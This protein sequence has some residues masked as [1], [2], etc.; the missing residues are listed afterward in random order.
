MVV[1]HALAYGTGDFN[2]HYFQLPPLLSYLLFFIYGVFF[3]IG[4]VTNLFASTEGFALYFLKD[5]TVFY[6]LG[7]FFLS[8]LP[9]LL[10]IYLVYRIYSI[11]F[12]R[13][14]ALFSALLMSVV[15]LN[16]INSHYL[17]HDM[18]MISFILLTYLRLLRLEKCYSLRNYI[19]AAIFL[20]CAIATKYNAALMAAPF[21]ITHIFLMKKQKVSLRGIIFSKYLWLSFLA[22][23][24]TFILLNPFALLGFREFITSFSKQTAAA[25]NMGWFHHIGYSLK[26]GIS[27]PILISGII[28]LISILLLEGK[29]AAI[30]LSFPVVFY[31]VLVFYSQPFS[32]YVL[33]LIP[34]LAMGSAYI[35]YGVIFKYF[36]NQKAKIAL[37]LFTALLATPTTIKSIDADNILRKKDTRIISAEW[38]KD[39]VPIGSRIAC[40]DT[41]FRP[42]IKQPYLQVQAKMKTLSSEKAADKAK[43]KKQNYLLKILDKQ[44]PG[45]PVYFLKTEPQ[46]QGQ[47]LN[48]MPSV[49]FNIDDL[50]RNSIDYVIINH[51]ITNKAK[52]DFMPELKKNSRLIKT[53][54]P[55]N[56]GLVR[57]SYD[58]YAT[59]SLPIVSK[60]LS[61]RRYNG[62][63]LEIYEIKK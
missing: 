23:V 42:V 14:G 49:G 35:L 11:F 41:F 26:E 40:D 15:F 46:N 18:L 38:I 20:G 32:R 53:F 33:P 28:G 16:V 9:G 60:E 51:T 31:T 54:T 57:L 29:R 7:R 8:L 47:F 63:V 62:P 59:T 10:N 4:K 5:P 6:L 19:Y 30:F 22:T 3:L 37:V 55:Y 43:L 34:F 58:K 36:K 1:N 50:A 2:P 25:W 44:D 45:Y 48:T 61:A 27:T 39:N 56:D 13:P 12:K 17:Y 52:E 24:A 21:L